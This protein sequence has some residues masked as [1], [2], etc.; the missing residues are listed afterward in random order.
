[1]GLAARSP[2]FQKAVGDARLLDI[3]AGILAPD[4]EF[5]SDKVVFKSESTTFAS[6]WHQD[7]HYWHGTPQGLD[8]GGT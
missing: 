6:P 4:I 7:W 1:M 5:L 2:V 8:L 3:L